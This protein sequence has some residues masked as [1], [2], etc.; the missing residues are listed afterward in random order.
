MVNPA[1]RVAELG[2]IVGIWAHPDDEVYLSAGIMRLAL[3]NGQRVVCVTATAGEHGTDDPSTWPPDV[4][5]A[6]RR[7]ELADS[8][9][10][11]GAGLRTGVEHHWLDHADGRCADAV[12]ERAVEPI[13]ELVEVVRPDTVLTFGP[14]GLTG[15][16][17]H[18]AVAGWVS[19]VLAG[20]P[21]IVRLDAAVARSWADDFGVAADTYFDPGSPQLV[22]DEAVAL[23]LVLTDELWSIKDAALRAHVT[24]TAPVIEHLG[25][26]SWRTFSDTETFVVHG[27]GPTPRPHVNDQQHE[28]SSPS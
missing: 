13:D 5:G 4:L 24:Q 10:A 15:H 21:G 25:P 17:D 3:A 8:F 26:R 27:D 19:A 28:S 11:L 22:D 7:R 1:Q 16:S 23:N 12:L 9:A 18:R 2:T 20:R 14:D 6:E